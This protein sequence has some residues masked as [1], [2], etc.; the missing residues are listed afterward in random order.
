MIFFHHVLHLLFLWSLH[1]CSN[2][3]WLPFFPSFSLSSSSSPLPLS[4]S[5]KRVL[6]SPACSRH[7]SASTADWRSF[8]SPPEEPYLHGQPG[9]SLFLPVSFSSCCSVKF[10]KLNILWGTG[11][12][13]FINL[14]EANISLHLRFLT[15]QD[16]IYGFKSVIIYVLASISVFL[17]FL[18]LFF[19]Y[20]STCLLRILQ[21]EQTIYTDLET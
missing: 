20:L 3:P 1:S 18:H 16:R 11:S 2:V 17:F 15:F 8:P 14:L 7:S 19:L 10:Q 21:F 6:T 4:T 5:P 13:N 12:F 9:E